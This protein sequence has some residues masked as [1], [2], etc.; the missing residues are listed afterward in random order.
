M[1]TDLTIEEYVRM[2]FDQLTINKIT[3]LFESLKEL[4]L[5]DELEA[6]LNGYAADVISHE[7]LPYPDEIRNHVKS[8]IIYY[9]VEELVEKHLGILVDKEM[10]ISIDFILGMS[11]LASNLKTY[12]S[13]VSEL[14]LSDL[15][16][17]DYTA[18]TKLGHAMANYNPDY[19]PLD[20]ENDL[21]NV[22]DESL[23]N[24]VANVED[25]IA[26]G[27]TDDEVAISIIETLHAV[28]PTLLNTELAR[29]IISTNAYHMT[30]CQMLDHID[31][32]LT[33]KE[34]PAKEQFKEFT[35]Y[36][37][38]T[39]T[40]GSDLKDVVVDLGYITAG[41]YIIIGADHD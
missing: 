24:M 25:T 10:D 11:I 33:S 28:D 32:Y 5:Y 34:I 13:G 2:D 16:S 37:V 38:L 19:Y 39:K 6:V 22:P 7:V 31:Q 18:S 17:E 35:T 14:V 8:I 36:G 4:Y 12:S 9:T 40:T 20:A 41:G 1:I 27:T 21:L 3:T 29:Y 26:V 15:T 30:G 23:A